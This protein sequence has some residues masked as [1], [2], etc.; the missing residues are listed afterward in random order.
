MRIAKPKLFDT[1]ARL[2]KDKSG[3]V[4]IYTALALP[5]LLGV[6]GLSVD[7]GSWYAN[8]RVAQASADAGAIAAALE[9]MR[10][11]IGGDD[12]VAY[13]VLEAVALSS[14]AEN[15]YDASGGDSIQINNPPTSG[16]YAGS[17]EYVEVIVQR[18]AQVFLA[19]F[20]FDQTVTVAGRA[21]AQAAFNEACIWG[22][23]P[24]ADKAVKVSG[25]AQVNLPCGIFSNSNAPEALSTDGGACITASRIKSVGGATGDCMNP[26]AVTGMRPITDP[27]A[28]MQPPSYGG[29]D[30]TGNIRVNNGETLTLAPGTYCGNI[31]VNGG[32][33]LNFDPGLYVLDTAGLNF[34]S[35]SQIV[36]NDVTF[37]LTENS[38]QG[39]NIKVAAGASVTLSAPIG[40]DLPGVLFYQD[41]N[42][43][44]DIRHTFTGQ[45]NMTL[46][47]IL[48]FPNQSLK[49]SGGG[50][51][52]PVTTVIVADTVEF[53][54]NTTTDNI[55][56][57]VVTGNPFLIVVHLVE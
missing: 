44:P 12:N 55:D 41:R 25:G 15:G 9:V 5:V 14:A 28:D 45:S 16:A 26:G 24:T 10:R 54:G 27:F 34:A 17:A 57:S 33:T 37:Y 50:V 52:D 56:G 42:S 53:T 40:G 8:K 19:G 47:G 7:V 1:C 32:G 38:N 11:G 35:S 43:P 20:L 6:S 23:S 2:W 31:T 13:S 48:Y 3:G 22:L 46:E 51:I 29:C 36:G 18:P 21:V 4:M 49:F 39:T 30:F